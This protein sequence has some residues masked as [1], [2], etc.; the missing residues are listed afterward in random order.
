M[1]RLRATGSPPVIL[2]ACLLVSLESSWVASEDD[3]VNRHTATTV[4]G[5]IV[6]SAM[7]IEVTGVIQCYCGGCSNQTLHDCTCG[8][9]ASERLRVA[10]ALAS[11]ATP[12][13]LI[14]EYVAQHGL[15]VRIVP[16]RRGFNL[17]GWA[18]PWLASLV[19]L[20]ALGI[21]LRAWAKR[22][23]EAAASTQTAPVAQD[24]RALRARV[25]KALS[26]ME[27]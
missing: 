10:A 27:S 3:L 24:E 26:E 18:V 23:T 5:P 12:G 1:S 6:E 13:S 2:L 19:A 9:A 22:S 16:E 20:V 15:Q 4:A 8:L 17:L 21:T 11:G 7:A 14:D 25:E